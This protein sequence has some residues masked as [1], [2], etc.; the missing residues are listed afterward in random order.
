MQR[1]GLVACAA[2][3]LGARVLEVLVA[4]CGPEMVGL[5]HW[6]R[7]IDELGGFPWKQVVFGD[8]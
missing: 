3:G 5:G 7:M 4:D 2:E 6:Y 1:A 8:L